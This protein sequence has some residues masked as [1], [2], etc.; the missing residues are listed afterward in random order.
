MTAV[1]PTPTN[2]SIPPTAT[3]TPIPPTATITPIPPT[4]GG[5]VFF[6]DF[7]TDQGWLVNPNGTDNATTGQWER[8]NPETTT[9]S[10]G[11]YQLGSTVSGSFD[12]V[13]GGAAG[14][15]VG[16]NDL[17]GGTTSVR[18][19]AISLPSGGNLTL[20]F[21]YYLAHLNNSSTSDFLRVSIVGNTTAVVFEQL[22]TRNNNVAIWD[23]F[24]VDLNSFAGQTVYILIEAADAGG[25]SLVE[26]GV[27]DVRVTNN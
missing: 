26:A 15:N 19:P 6:D 25:G 7:E 16:A 5:D 4:P 8:A 23:S 18:S 20:S 11:T 27:D 12:L 13:T 1:P 14:S 24:S 17:D 3:N 10:G 21:D 22:G 2:T 9:Y